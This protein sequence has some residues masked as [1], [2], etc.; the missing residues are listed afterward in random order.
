MVRFFILIL[1]MILTLCEHRPSLL[2][3]VSKSSCCANW[4]LEKHKDLEKNFEILLPV[5]YVHVS[6]CLYGIL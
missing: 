3:S 1:I 4:W 5:K 2:F 6:A